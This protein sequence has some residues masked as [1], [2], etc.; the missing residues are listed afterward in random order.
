[1]NDRIDVE[2]DWQTQSVT[3]KV[4]SGLMLPQSVTVP[5]VAVKGVTANI[6]LAEINSQAQP[7]S[8]I[9]VPNI[10]VPS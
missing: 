9:G 2:I 1:M 6:I 4:T 3:F 7:T 10:T 8:R 5:F